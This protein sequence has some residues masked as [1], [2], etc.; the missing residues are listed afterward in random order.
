[1][2]IPSHIESF[3]EVWSDFRRRIGFED[4]ADTLGLVPHAVTETSLSFAMPLRDDIAQVGGK[5][6]AAALFGAADITGT[7]LAIQVF[8]DQGQFPLAVQSNINFFSNSQN[9]PAIAT[10]TLL[11]GGRS[12]VVAEVSVADSAGKALS[13][14]TFTYVL[15]ENQVGKGVSSAAVPATGT[16]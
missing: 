2:A 12:V 6:S 1:M 11:K 14:A 7:F 15:K 13:N 3:R 4:I 16:V 5:F 8:S 10:A 9:G